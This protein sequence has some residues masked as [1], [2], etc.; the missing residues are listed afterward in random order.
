MEEGEG[1]NFLRMR[2]LNSIFG[3]ALA[4]VKKIL[5]EVE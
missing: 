2:G 3:V 1:A 5:V 4:V